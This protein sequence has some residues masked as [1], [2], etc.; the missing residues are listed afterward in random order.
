MTT[1][2]DQLSR[3]IRQY[4]ATKSAAKSAQEAVEVLETIIKSEMIGQGLSTFECDGKTISLIHSQRRSFDASLL[5][6]LVKPAVFNTVTEYEV[7]STLIDAAVTSGKI[8]K[9]VADQ[10]TSTTRYTQIRIK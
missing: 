4:L 5:K 8:D 3:T 1:T 10:I 2:N 9:T 6:T 7:K